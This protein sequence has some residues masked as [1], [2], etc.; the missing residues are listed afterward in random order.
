[1]PS[2]HGELI[3][4]LDVRGALFLAVTTKKIKKSAP[5]RVGPHSTDGVL[6]R[7]SAQLQME[8]APQHIGGHGSERNAASRARL[9]ALP[10]A[11][12]SESHGGPTCEGR[13]SD[14]LA[15][16]RTGRRFV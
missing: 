11:G 2:K 14:C 8:E 15:S 7:L 1:M 5:K 10:G 13:Q 9:L 6:T 4:T 16:G 3:G 12:W